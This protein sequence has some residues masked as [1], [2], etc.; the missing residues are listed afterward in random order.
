VQ[1]FRR[2]DFVVY[3]ELKKGIYIRQLSSDGNNF[4]TA[5][6]LVF[7]IGRD[8]FSRDILE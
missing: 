2:K 7:N 8:I 3:K 1:N 4:Q 6:Q 5:I